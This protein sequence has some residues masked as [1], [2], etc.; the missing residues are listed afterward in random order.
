MCSCS[1]YAY[2]RNAA[3]ERKEKPD[4]HRAGG[5]EIFSQISG[6][7]RQN[8][9]GW[10]VW[11]YSHVTQDNSRKIYKL[12]KSFIGA[13]PRLDAEHINVADYAS[14]HRERSVVC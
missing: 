5:R 13:I 1:L 9:E 4:F 6:D 2:F 7:S 10:R 14:C 12:Q 11:L 3:E 8:Q